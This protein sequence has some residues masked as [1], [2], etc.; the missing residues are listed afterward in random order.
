V[1]IYYAPGLV[2]EPL[3]LIS[4]I[5]Y[6][7]ELAAHSVQAVNNFTWITGGGSGEKTIAQ[8]EGGMQ[9]SAR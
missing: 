6:H 3:K 4:P 1:L 8:A 7:L 9:A 5:I 2:Y